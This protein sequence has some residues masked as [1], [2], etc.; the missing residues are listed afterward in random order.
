MIIN[1]SYTFA[2]GGTDIGN[3]TYIVYD[4]TGTVGSS[5]PI[6]VTGLAAGTTYYFQVFE[7]NG[8]GT[9]SVFLNTTNTNNPN[10]FTTLFGQPTVQSSLLTF[11]NITATS[12]RVNFTRAMERVLVACKL[13]ST[14]AG[15]PTDGTV[16]TASSVFGEGSLIGTSARVIFTGNQNYCDVTG[17]TAGTTYY[18]RVYEYN[19][20]GANINYF[21]DE[22]TDNPSSQATLAGEPTTQASGI[23]FSDYR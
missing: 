5:N 18:F 2:G 21:T 8:T 11:T 15:T 1:A 12:M 6:T 14:I 16:Y 17:L 7:Y 19:N 13:G 20:S 4:G 10:S 22:A 9:S 3:N 23:V